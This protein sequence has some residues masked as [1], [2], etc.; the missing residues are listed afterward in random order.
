MTKVYHL[1][2][3]DKNG[4]PFCWGFDFISLRRATAALLP[5]TW[6]IDNEG[7]V[8]AKYGDKIS[9]CKGCGEDYNVTAAK[10][11]GCCSTQ[12]VRDAYM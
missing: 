3:N 11:H 12:C 10:R 4:R 1:V 7:E 6:V 5:G 8:I 9:L 2:D